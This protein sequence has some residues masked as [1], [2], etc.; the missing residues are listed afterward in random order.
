MD[1]EMQRLD[2]LRL[3]RE[4]EDDPLA[5]ARHVTHLLTKD[6]RD[7]RHGGPQE[8]GARETNLLEGSIR[9]GTVE[10]AGGVSI[11]LPEQSSAPDGERVSLSIRPESLSIGELARARQV[12][13]SAI[14]EE[15]VFRGTN[16]VVAMKIA[17][18]LRLSALVSSAVASR[19]AVGSTV[20]LGFDLDS[21]L[22]FPAMSG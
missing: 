9:D 4:A 16:A 6:R 3:R 17:E 21:V 7:G 11:P 14:V 8:E 2:L 12:R 10:L 13:W 5:E 18:G 1:D 15:T 19:I 20:N 22:V